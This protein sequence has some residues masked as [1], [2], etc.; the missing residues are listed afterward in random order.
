[1]QESKILINNIS[2]IGQSSGKFTVNY[3][4]LID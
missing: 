3:E 1:L 2:E 4:K